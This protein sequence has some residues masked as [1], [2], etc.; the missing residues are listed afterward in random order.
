MALD[1][2]PGV[3]ITTKNERRLKELLSKG[4]V[5]RPLANPP[6]VAKRRRQP[7]LAE[8]LS[9]SVLTVDEAKKLFRVSRSTI[10][11][12]ADEGKLKRASMGK[13]PGKRTRFL[14]LTESA[15]KLLEESPE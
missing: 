15:K 4:S 1:D 5:F 2:L 14:I 9:A 6:S 3:P 10:C 8:T 7:P 13:K 11:R 12:W